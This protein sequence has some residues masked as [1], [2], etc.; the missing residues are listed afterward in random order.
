[1][2]A[3]STLQ[4]NIRCV[5]KETE[6]RKVFDVLYSKLPLRSVFKAMAFPPELPCIYISTHL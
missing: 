1:M 4:R 3:S 5:L 2:S 6:K